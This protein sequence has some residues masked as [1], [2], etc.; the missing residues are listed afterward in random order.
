MRETGRVNVGGEEKR[1]K[2]E[3]EGKQH[4]RETETSRRK[5]CK[6]RKS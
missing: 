1:K 6:H 3:G 2:T 4:E 5:E